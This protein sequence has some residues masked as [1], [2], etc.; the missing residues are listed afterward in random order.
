M[1]ITIK[2]AYIILGA[3]LMLSA[4]GQEDISDGTTD[5][6]ERIIFRTALPDVSSRAAEITT[7]FSYFHLTAFNPADPDLIAESSTL[8]EYINNESIVKG[9]GQNVLTSDKCIWPAPGKDGNMSFFAYYPQLPSSAS[10]ANGSTVSEGS[11]NIDYKII[12]YSIAPDIAD[13]VDFVTAS[14]TG[15]KAENLFSGITLN[16]AHQ[17]SRI[18]V[19]ARGANESCNIEIAGVRIGGAGVKGTF[20]FSPAEGASAWTALEKGNVEYIYR[21]GEEIVSLPR[22]NSTQTT[23]D[24]PVSIMGADLGSEANCAMLIPTTDATG[25]RYADDRQ[26]T[27]R[28]MY[29]SVLMRITDAAEAQQYPYTDNKEGL[30]ALNIP[31]VYLAVE[32][33]TG[34]VKANPGK[35]YRGDDKY[36]TD[37]ERTAEYVAPEGCTV[38]EFGWAAVPVTG[39]WKSGYIYTYTLDYTYGVGLHDPAV[40]GDVAPQ[41]GDPVISDKVFVSVTVSGWKP[42][43][44]NGVEV[45]R[46]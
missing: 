13:Q 30:N 40:E 2:P 31:V 37:S 3:T 20:D 25:W 17:L 24:A 39:E 41:A 1:N 42:G 8:S 46:K 43:S 22:K 4:C 9:L 10:L 15:S 34:K 32:N 14:T 36:Y 21:E 16:F 26:N 6:G 29:I 5:T 11:A 35:L 7:D 12:D 44:E 19:K 28:G 33:S 27:G 45:P 38:K 23:S 18:E